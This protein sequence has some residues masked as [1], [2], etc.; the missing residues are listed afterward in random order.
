MHVI[1]YALITFLIMH[2]PCLDFFKTHPSLWSSDRLGGLVSTHTQV[3]AA[4]KQHYKQH[5]STPLAVTFLMGK[6]G[7]IVVD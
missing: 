4:T 2:A 1:L 7:I 5:I 6:G 3:Y